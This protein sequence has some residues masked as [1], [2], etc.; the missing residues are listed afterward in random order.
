MGI[1]A[2]KRLIGREIGPVSTETVT[3]FGQ[4]VA[5]NLV[6]F[7][8]ALGLLA[9]PAVA[10]AKPASGLSGLDLRLTPND[11][12]PPPPAALPN[13]PEPSV[14]HRQNVPEIV[15][16]IDQVQRSDTPQKR[17]VT[18]PLESLSGSQGVLK[19]LL[20]NKTIPLFRVSVPPP[21]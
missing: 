1:H 15:G 8:L 18:G 19:E 16:E 12:A 3:S 20:E 5:R 14:L 2:R 17:T 9:G 4:H 7:G 10:I 13:S 21:F 11:V 6:G